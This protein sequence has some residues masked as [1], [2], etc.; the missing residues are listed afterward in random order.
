MKMDRI[1]FSMGWR[2]PGSRVGLRDRVFVESFELE[3]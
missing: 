2:F 1:D 3:L